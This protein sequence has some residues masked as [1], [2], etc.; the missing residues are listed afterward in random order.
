MKLE[1]LVHDAPSL[2]LETERL[3]LRSMTEADMPT[4]IVHELDRDTM[5][6]IRDPL[7]RDEVEKRVRATLEPWQGEDGQWLIL[8]AQPKDGAEMTGIVCLRVTTADTETMEIGYRFQSDVR[9][10]GF[11]FEACRGLIDYLFGK[12]EVRRIVALC[13][14][15]NEASW[16]LMK[17]VGMKQEGTFREYS[18]LS[19][20]WRD[21]FV[22][23]LLRREWQERS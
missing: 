15:E 8:A 1:Q 3:V 13:V 18:Y 21:E 16:R 7:P 10:R 4:A 20:A 23:A 17:K 12:I 14:A 11:G 22:Y 6:W 9:R 5:H 19:G 2:R